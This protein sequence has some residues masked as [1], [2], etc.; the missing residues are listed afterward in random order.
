MSSLE[1][2]KSAWTDVS[3]MLEVVYEEV[4][5][6]YWG[7]L[8][9][10]Y[11]LFGHTDFGQAKV[12]DL[13]DNPSPEEIKGWTNASSLANKLNFLKK[14]VFE[15]PRAAKDGDFIG[16]TIYTLSGKSP[17][18]G[19]LFSFTDVEKWPQQED[20]DNEFF[21]ANILAPL[22]NKLVQDFKVISENPLIAA[23]D[24]EFFNF[25]TEPDDDSV[26]FLQEAV[27]EAASYLSLFPEYAITLKKDIKPL[28]ETSGKGPTPIFSD[29]NLENS[30][31]IQPGY[32]H[33]IGVNL[34]PLMT[35]KPWYSRY[36]SPYV[37]VR[38]SPFNDPNAATWDDT[39]YSLVEL[40]RDADS[41]LKA[42][43]VKTEQKDSRG[44]VIPLGTGI[45]ITEIVESET[46]TWVGFVSD[47]IPAA[48]TDNNKKVIY[49]KAE[50]IR[51]RE[52]A[53]S[54]IPDPYLSR[55][56]LS[57]N[58]SLRNNVVGTIP[59]V[60]GAKK[61]N[62]KENQNWVSLN[63]L[64]IRI[65]RYDFTEHNDK[66]LKGKA[67]YTE[68][69]VA[70]N[71]ALRYSYGDYY[72]VRGEIPRQSEQ[73]IAQDNEEDLELDEEALEEKK[74]QISS[75]T[76]NTLKR[77]AWKN[78][79]NYLNKHHDLEGEKIQQQLFDKYFVIAGAKV[80][81][82]SVNPNNQ[83][84]LFAIRTNYIDALPEKKKIYT[85]DFEDHEKDFANGNNFSTTFRLRE[86]KA[87]IESLKKK[88]EDI[89]SKIRSS[90]TKVQ[91]PN[92]MDY[93]I[94]A[95]IQLLEEI[96]NIFNRFFS[97]QTFS[98]GGSTDSDILTEMI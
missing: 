35:G 28:A 14:E 43:Q 29:I 72:F 18:H 34:K 70:E 33:Y 10:F 13:G 82:S 6:Q 65:A 40:Y 75:D 92:N 90:N 63:P 84:V 67:E 52:S 88:F 2:K 30:L 1:D 62:P 56:I 16:D 26:Q 59:N 58:P 46:G 11:A 61:V 55:K 24:G 69:T 47:N 71:A 89:R 36:S 49:T 85:D 21:H 96:P 51:I 86:F 77:E 73:E 50:Y 32:T 95:Q 98:G 81:T 91:N 79:L 25:G 78:L 93:D 42:R 15:K 12:T 8:N 68:K 87:N 9:D 53:I 94:T 3:D 5:E 17:E 57:S 60:K 45:L 4:L 41:K 66:I 23:P 54:N 31:N 22:V 39:N 27:E 74:K 19:G 80:N 76:V 20:L 37:P 97:R 48:V 64:D 7:S 44:I 83:K 38:Y